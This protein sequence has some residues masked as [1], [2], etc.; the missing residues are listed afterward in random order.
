MK[1]KIFIGSSVEGLSV[2][3]SIQQNLAHDAEATVWDQGVFELSS[4]TMESLNKVLTTI[5][6]GIFVFSPD[7]VTF[8]RGVTSTTVRDNVLFELGLFIGKIGRERV[9]FIT[10]TSDLIRLP[11]DLLGVTPAYYEPKRDDG[12]LQA[13]TGAACNQIR[14]QMKKLGLLRPEIA[15]EDVGMQIDQVIEKEKENESDWLLDFMGAEYHAA[16]QK[17]ISLIAKDVDAIESI[18]NKVWLAYTELKIN[19]KVGL[20]SLRKLA[21]EYEADLKN[22]SF[23]I[24]IFNWEDYYSDAIEIGESALLK[25]P[26]DK[27]LIIALS[28]C[29]IKDDKDKA[30]TLLNKTSPENDP[31]IAVTLANI[32]VD[33]KLPKQAMSILNATHLNFPNNELTMKRLAELNYESSLFKESLYLYRTL[34]INHP[35]NSGYLGNFSNV[36]L[37]LDLYNE[38]MVA[39][40]KASEISEDKEAW[41]SMNIGNLLNNKGF[42][43]DAAKHLNDAVKLEPDSEYAHDRLSKAIKNKNEENKKLSEFIKEGRNLIKNFKATSE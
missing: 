28:S 33:S 16:K 12:S 15:N 40:R 1:P 39:V 25:Y 4:T 35:K 8:M 11:T 22:L 29:Y 43:S 5:D 30:I 27:D 7:D 36:C 17:L 42:Y 3:Y 6:F 41:F 14:L 19:E 31:E 21:N 2:A 26:T 24:N 23:I 18:H 34:T 9:F 32:Y 13:A 37:S 10:P 20:E 38:S